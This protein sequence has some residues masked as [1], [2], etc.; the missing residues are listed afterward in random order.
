MPAA[1]N[2]LLRIAALARQAQLPARTVRFYADVGLIKPARRGENGYRFFGS[3]AIERVQL[4]RRASHLGVPLREIAKVL[5]I[6]EGADCADAHQ[7]FA[8]ALRH[9]IA[10]VDREMHELASTREQLVDLAAESDVGC[11]D[12]FC[13]C[14]TKPGEAIPIAWDAPRRRA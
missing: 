12:A 7:A 9:R 3:D 2:G 13:L 8:T 10:Q 4:L 6:A 5:A 11:S 1:A 14:R